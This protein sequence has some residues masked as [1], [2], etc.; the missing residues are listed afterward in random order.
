[1]RYVEVMGGAEQAIAVGRK[2]FE[3]GEYRWAAEVLNH[4]VFADPH[5]QEARELQADTM[6]QMGYQAESGSWRGHYL[7]GAQELRRGTPNIPIP[8]TATP[9]TVRGMSLTLLFNYFAMRIKG[10]EAAGKEITLNLVFTDTGDEAVLELRSG[11]LNHSLDR[12]ADAPDATVTLERKDLD[13]VIIGDADLVEEAKRGKIK[14]EPD[15]SPLA[16]L[17]DL[18][19]DFDI[20]F[21]VIEP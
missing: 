4:V 9:D 15:V 7:T 12:Q 3:E 6:E 20:W 13:A 17:V 19:D 18:L 14:V 2:A 10:P 8:G 11:T 1:V 21:N 16:E 5:N